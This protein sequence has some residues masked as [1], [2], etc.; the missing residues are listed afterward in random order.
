MLR[1]RAAPRYSALALAAAILVFGGVSVS[2]LISIHRQ[3][4]DAAW[5]SHSYEVLAQIET[6]L[7]FA[8]E[9]RRGASG[10]VATGDP[11]RLQMVLNAQPLTSGAV[12]R[13]GALMSDNPGQFDRVQRVR[14]LL[15]DE[16]SALLAIIDLRGRDP[17]AATAMLQSGDWIAR[18]EAVQSLARDMTAA[19]HQLLEVRNTR[20]Q[21]SLQRTRWVVTA[22]NVLAFALTIGAFVM[23]EREGRQR[24][25]AERQLA[26]AHSE[27]TGRVI[28]LQRL[29]TELSLLTRLSHLLQSCDTRDESAAVVRQIVPQLFPDS[30]GAVYTI[31][32]SRNLVVP[33]TA[34]PEIE[35]AVPPFPPSACWALRRGALHD[36]GPDGLNIR[37]EHARNLSGRT[38]CVPLI[39]Q[40]E[41]LGLLEIDSAPVAHAAGLA[42]AVAQQ[43]SL[44][45]GNLLMQETL[46]RQAMR[47]SLTGVFNRR[48]MEETLARE[49]YRAARQNKTIGVLLLD[50]DH[51][52]EYND[53]LGHAAG[54][55]LLRAAAAI[56][57]RVVRAEDVVCRYGGDEFVIIMPEVET[58]TAMRRAQSLLDGMQQLPRPEAASGPVVTVSI[59]V[60][61][62]PEDGIEPKELLD[63][64]DRAL[65]D[66]KRGGRARVVRFT[67]T[68]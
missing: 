25:A 1:E 42:T 4:Q 54:D 8:T 63:A 31:A 14:S 48:Y 39:A 29:S 38:L 11:R 46:R 16:R 30:Q 34:W 68:T 7:R 36:S 15:D 32:S 56:M 62:Y 13:L 5:V 26:A 21:T 40:G 9:A 55:D 24:R 60:A 58:A 59:G 53:T 17:A 23:S 19:E 57:Q 43:L 22:G 66:A 28:D 50:F 44:A 52:K 65:Y 20:Q 27:L 3:A 47:D 33:L 67:K 37:C 41:T 6:M 49:I 10:Y 12:N 18:F 2:S 45:Q 64:T 35:R 51:F 61:M